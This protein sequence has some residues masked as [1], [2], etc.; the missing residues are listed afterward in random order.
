MSYGSFYL[1]N[2]TVEK[3]PCSVQSY[4][5]SDINNGQAYKIHAFTNTENNE[6]GW[7]YPSSSSE[8][9]DRYVIFNTQEKVWY[10]GQLER[11]SWLDSGVVS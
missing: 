8:E 3:L 1:Y 11:T 9:I 4:V 10:Y 2:G 7:F 6:V 5:F